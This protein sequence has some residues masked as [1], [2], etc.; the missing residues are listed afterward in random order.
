MGGMVA[1]ELA[2]KH[3]LLPTAIILISSGVL[4]TEAALRGQE[5]VL[6]DLRSGA[7]RTTIQALVDQICLPSDRFKSQV[8]ETFF[9]NSSSAMGCAF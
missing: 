3:P 8:E 9:C 1:V 4:F 5:K 6:R 7:Y 2:A